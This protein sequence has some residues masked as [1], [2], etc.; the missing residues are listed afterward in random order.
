M[1]ETQRCQDCGHVFSEI[2]R[3]GP[4]L[5]GIGDI[6]RHAGE[7]ACP[8][9][10]GAVKWVSQGGSPLSA[11]KRLEEAHHHLRLGCLWG[12]IAGGIALIGFLIAH[13]VLK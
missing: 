2:E 11:N 7:K 3:T 4:S 13:F 6:M 5:G 10:G 9:C 1:R 8:R 12:A